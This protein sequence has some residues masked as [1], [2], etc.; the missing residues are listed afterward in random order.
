MIGAFHRKNLLNNYAN[1]NIMGFN[2]NQMAD[3][4]NSIDLDYVGVE[5]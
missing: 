2:F 5:R 1:R 4:L 3:I